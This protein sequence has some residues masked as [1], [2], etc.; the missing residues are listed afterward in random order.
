[1]EGKAG[2]K[3]WHKSNEPWGSE[4]SVQDGGQLDGFMT[5]ADFRK[6]E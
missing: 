5:A 1:M 2:G 3:K 6:Y 4:K